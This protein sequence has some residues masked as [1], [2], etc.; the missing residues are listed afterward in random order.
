MKRYLAMSSMADRDYPAEW[1]ELPRHERRQKLKAL[2]HEQD[3]RAELIKKARNWGLAAL[4]VGVGIFGYVQLIKKSS[5]QIE[6]EQRIEIVSL[7]DRVEEFQIEGSDHVLAG[8]NVSYQTNPPT[9]GSHLG[10]A[11][12]WGVYDQEIDDLM[13]VHSLEHG[14]IWISYRDI[15]DDEIAILET[16]GRQNSLSTVVSPRSGNDDKVVVASWGKM[17]RLESVDP[18]L[19]QKYIDTYKNQ[20]PEKLAR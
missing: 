9:S 13:A 17:M 14:G 6:L 20:S 7:D 18:A 2:R 5:E 15:S 19:I 4:A 16:I 1:D 11:E 10:R 3:K 12:N 8:T